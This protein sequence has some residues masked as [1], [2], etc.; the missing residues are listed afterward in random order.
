ME[1]LKTSGWIWICG[2][3]RSADICSWQPALTCVEV[4]GQRCLGGA[5][6]AGRQLVALQSH[7]VMPAVLLRQNGF[8]GT[9]RISW[10]CCQVVG[11]NRLH[12]KTFGS[13][14]P[15]S[16]VSV[17]R[18]DLD[19]DGFS[20]AFVIEL[21]QKQRWFGARE[22]WNS[23]VWAVGTWRHGGLELAFS[24]ILQVGCQV[25]IKMINMYLMPFFLYGIG[26]FHPQNSKLKT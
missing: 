19:M 2:N 17:L 9:K 13:W 14:V 16:E 18:S 23:G 12:T 11:P 25:T 7:H 20:E 15:S 3:I 10:I 4:A 8:W 1:I 6:G 26:E 24:S 21:H 22:L 5:I